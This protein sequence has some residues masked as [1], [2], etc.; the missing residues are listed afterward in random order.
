MV[1]CP[2]AMV[3]LLA[4]IALNKTAFGMLLVVAFSI[5]LA[6]TLM[7]IGLIVL[8]ARNRIQRPTA[9]ASWPK[10]LPVLSAGAVTIIGALLCYGALTG[11]QF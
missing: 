7:A 8:Y 5:G 11:S 3:L 1:P 2:S 4:A 9:G 10:L 6:L